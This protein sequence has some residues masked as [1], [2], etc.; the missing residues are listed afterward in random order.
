M[1]VNNS[2]TV[3]CVLCM[4]VSQVEDQVFQFFDVGGQRNERRKW[5]HCFEGECLSLS[6]SL[7]VSLSLCLSVSVCLYVSLCLSLPLSLFFSLCLS[8]L[9]LCLSLSLSVSLCHSVSLSLS[10]CCLLSAGVHGVMFLSAL[11]EYDQ[12]L[13]EANEINR[14]VRRVCE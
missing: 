1:Y 7:S 8:P 14:M 12:K 10:H 5:I 11:S 9:S 2:L 3:P 13:F 6:L 4:C